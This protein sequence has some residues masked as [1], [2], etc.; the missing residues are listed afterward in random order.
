MLCWQHE[1]ICLELFDLHTFKALVLSTK[2]Y[3]IIE[4][5]VMFELKGGGENLH[6][7]LLVNKRWSS[8]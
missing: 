4:H 3:G 7:L 6:L 5:N 1:T 8:T 2:H